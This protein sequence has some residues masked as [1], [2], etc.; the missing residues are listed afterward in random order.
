MTTAG[1]KTGDGLIK[2][3]KT[4]QTKTKKPYIAMRY[5]FSKKQQWADVSGQAT[6]PVPQSQTRDK[7]AWYASSW[8]TL[9]WWTQL[10]NTANHTGKE[11][12]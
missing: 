10:P 9:L 11:F 1:G 12:C 3:N 4:H 5:Q 6:L 2:K 7:P 8:M